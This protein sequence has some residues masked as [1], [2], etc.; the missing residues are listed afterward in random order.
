MHLWS[1][2]NASSLLLCR[3]TSGIA[4]KKDKLV[5]WVMIFLAVS[6]STAAISSD[7]YS[8]FSREKVARS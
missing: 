7:I 5:S 4:T 3:N 8:I 2:E 1:F 6:S